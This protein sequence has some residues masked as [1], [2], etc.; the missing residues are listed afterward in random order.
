TCSLKGRKQA[1]SVRQAPKKAILSD[2]ESA[3][4]KLR[5]SPMPSSGSNALTWFTTGASMRGRAGACQSSTGARISGGVFTLRGGASGI[6]RRGAS[7][8]APAFLAPPL[9]AGAPV[10]FTVFAPPVFGLRAGAGSSVNSDGSRMWSHFGQ[11]AASSATA[12]P[13]LGHFIWLLI[14]GALDCGVNAKYPV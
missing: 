14:V 9:V 11:T 2:S 4:M 7:F 6:M 1:T 10:R 8:F 3:T 5:A 13:Q 12:V